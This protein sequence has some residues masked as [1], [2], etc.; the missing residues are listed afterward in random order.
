MGAV[1]DHLRHV[2]AIDGERAGEDE[3]RA[4][5]G[6]AHRLE[7]HAGAVEVDPHAEVEVGLG[8]GTDDGGQMPDD[9]GLGGEAADGGRDRR[10]RP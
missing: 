5:A 9:V 6:G 1:L 10:C 3:A 4:P 7:E 8:V 2:A